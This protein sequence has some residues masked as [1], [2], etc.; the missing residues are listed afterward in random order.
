[1]EHGTY[2]LASNKS[3]YQ[4]QKTNNFEFIVTFGDDDLIREGTPEGFETNAE[5]IIK[6][7]IA[8]ETLRLSVNKTSIPHFTQS[9]IE[10]KRGNSTMKF[11]GT[12]TFSEG[13]LEIEDYVNADSKSIL[14][15]WQRLSY[16]VE[17]EKVGDASQYKKDCT[18]IEYTPNYRQVRYWVLKGCWISGLSEP[19]FDSYADTKNNISVTIQYDY[20]IMHMPDEE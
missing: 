14:M 11:A 7:D 3:L 5:N 6:S 10:V 13:S 12:P 20:A 9:V 16:D 8:Q 2:H 4:P 17:T 18:L 1:M 15:A 19:G